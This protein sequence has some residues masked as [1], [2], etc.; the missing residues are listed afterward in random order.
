MVNMKRFILIFT[1]FMFVANTVAVSAWAKPCMNINEASHAADLGKAG[2]TENMPCHEKQDQKGPLKHCDGICLCFHIS[3]H[4][5]PVLTPYDDYPDMPLTASER[6]I[7]Q[8]DHVSSILMAP[9]H[10]PP[11]ASS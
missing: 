11:K 4:Q 3:V 9:P 5:T 1:V 10:R 2:G 6:L 8:D 7:G